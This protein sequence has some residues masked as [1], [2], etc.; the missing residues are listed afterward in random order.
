METPHHCN[1]NCNRSAKE[2]G[3]PFT[4]GL[5]ENLDNDETP[6]T[7]SVIDFR[8]CSHEKVPAG[9][10]L[11]L[12]TRW[13]RI[14]C[15]HM[16]RDRCGP[17]LHPCSLHS[18][19]NRVGNVVGVWLLL[20][21]LGAVKIHIGAFSSGHEYFKNACSQEVGKNSYACHARSLL[22]MKLKTAGGGGGG[23][24][25]QPSLLQTQRSQHEFGKDSVAFND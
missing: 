6:T 19:R 10:D 21:F 15:Q 1:H 25:L 20:S 17:S 4:K 14:P 13:V 3:Y 16:F 8:L 2:K 7:P 22:G 12:S 23:G 18:L 24:A 9:S 5:L 11:L